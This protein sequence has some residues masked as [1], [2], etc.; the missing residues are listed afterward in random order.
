VSG[1]LG[2]AALALLAF[3]I[4]AEV[5]RELCF[6]TGAQRAAVREENY[7]T[8]VLREPIVWIGILAWAVE[9][10]A[11]VMVLQRVPLGIAFPV[12]A[13]T[14]AGVPLAGVLLLG[15]RL[16][17]SQ[18]AGAALVAAGVFCVALSGV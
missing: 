16:S 4:V 7:A 2:P 5:G 14:Y 17:R 1:V 18:V 3:C 6:K 9:L 10:A 8:A 15:E 12:M 13:L 11:W